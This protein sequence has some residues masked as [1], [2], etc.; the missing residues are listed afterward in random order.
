MLFLVDPSKEDIST[1]TIG[2][3]D[4][5]DTQGW[6]EAW[7]TPFMGKRSNV[8]DKLEEL[9][10]TVI[11]K[12]SL[13]DF[14]E[15][16][17]LLKDYHESGLGS[18]WFAWF[19]WY[20][21]NVEGFFEDTFKYGAKEGAKAYGP[22]WE[23]QNFNFD[24]GHHRQHIGASAYSYLGKKIYELINKTCV[25]VKLLNSISLLMLILIHR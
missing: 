5:S 12:D 13:A 2:F 23:G 20:W 17:Q 22:V 25:P 11:Y 16:T 14:M 6:P 21:L 4:N 10:A 1:Y 3:S 24:N 18:K 19:D 9:G 8:P 7:D 15:P